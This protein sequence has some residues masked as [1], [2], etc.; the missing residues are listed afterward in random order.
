M[1]GRVGHRPTRTRGPEQAS[2]AEIDGGSGAWRAAEVHLLT[3]IV[4]KY[5]ESGSS[6]KDARSLEDFTQIPV[7]PQYPFLSQFLFGEQSEPP[8]LFGE[9]SEPLS[10]P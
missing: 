7:I 8:F 3:S 1:M 4:R 2:G 5:Q 6:P 9:Q 10:S